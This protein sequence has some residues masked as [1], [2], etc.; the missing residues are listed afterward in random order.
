MNRFIKLINKPSGNDMFVCD[1]SGCDVCAIRFKCFTASRIEIVEVDWSK[2]KT[3]KSPSRFLAGVT[4]SKIYVKGS[5][6]HKLIGMKILGT[7]NVKPLV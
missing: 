4:G 2:I 3:Y 5:K 1:G 6:R 7:E